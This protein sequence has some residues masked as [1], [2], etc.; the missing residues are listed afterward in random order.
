LLYASDAGFRLVFGGMRP[1][2][3][4]R[5]FVEALGFKDYGEPQ[6]ARIPD[7]NRMDQPLLTETRGNRER[8]LARKLA[9][10]DRLRA[11]GYDII[12]RGCTAQ[13]GTGKGQ[14]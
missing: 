5:P 7:G 6:F 13:Q 2:R 11:K 1:D 9:T 4:F 12:D 10:L 14:P 3:K 8:W